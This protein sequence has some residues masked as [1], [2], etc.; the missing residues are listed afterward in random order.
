[1]ADEPVVVETPVAGEVAAPAPEGTA[2]P[3]ADVVA[4][5]ETQP[6]L[7]KT[8][9]QE[10]LDAAVGK[11]LATEKRKWER[12]QRATAPT[13]AAGEPSEGAD[14]DVNVRAEQ[15]ANQREQARRNAEIV[16]AYQERE[17]S[18]REKYDD[19]EQ[20]AYNPRLPISEP[21]AATIRESEIG[22]EVLYY[23]GSD[24]NFAEAKRISRLS[25]LS[26]AKEIGKL[27]TKLASNP[28]ARKT[29][30]APAPIAPLSGR[31]TT[32]PTYDTTDPR[33]IQTM[34]TS[35]WIQKERERQMKK[36]GITNPR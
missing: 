22:P 31:G 14:A 26:Q 7:P 27:E 5:P 20:V 1:M 35:T 16:E 11:R 29:S 25:P 18:A 6:E 8:F 34:D 17:D 30:S 21:M 10:E 28:P 23:L 36:Q 15:I 32:T 4:T 9:T 19:F 33:S 3:V 13:P 12:A 24:P 2:P